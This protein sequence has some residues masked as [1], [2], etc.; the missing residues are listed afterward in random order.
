M[1]TRKLEVRTTSGHT[2]LFY[3]GDE[4]PFASYLSIERAQ[5]VAHR[6]NTFLP[7]LSLFLD[8]KWNPNEIERS[9]KTIADT[10]RGTGMFDIILG[11]I[12]KR[13]PQDNLDNFGLEEDLGEPRDNDAW[14]AKLK[15][16]IRRIL[17]GEDERYDGD[18]ELLTSAFQYKHLLHMQ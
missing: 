16:A 2:Q 6:W 7:L 12:M 8:Q 3:E 11:E 17:A 10:I 13:H 14:E 1:E 18:A 5:E 15:E 9:R 4:Y